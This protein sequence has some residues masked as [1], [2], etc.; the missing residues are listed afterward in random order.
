MHR[1]GK[2]SL[3]FTQREDDL[4]RLGLSLLQKC[5]AAL[6]LLAYGF[7]V[8]SIDEY[9]KLARSTTLECLE[10][11]CE[12]IIH[13]YGEEFC[14]QPNVADTQRL[15]AKAEDCGFPGMLGSIDCMQWQWR[16]CPVAYVGQFTRTDIKHPTIILEVVASYD[17]WILHAF[18][19]GRVQQ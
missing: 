1:L 11:F 4:G 5:I 6:H 19:G 7:V 3:Y 12:G 17:R 13:C 16:N 9:L 8:Y 14:R 18:L 10:K 15:Q 2:Y